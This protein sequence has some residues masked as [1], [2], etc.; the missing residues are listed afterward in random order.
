MVNFTSMRANVDINLLSNHLC[1][2]VAVDVDN[3]VVEV[4]GLYSNFNYTV[5][6]N[7]FDLFTIKIN[8]ELIT[9]ISQT[10]QGESYL[11][12]LVENKFQI[13]NCNLITVNDGIHIF[14][15]SRH[16]T[17]NNQKN[18]INTYNFWDVFTSYKNDT[19]LLSALNYYYER[20]VSTDFFSE[21]IL[22]STASVT[23]SNEQGNVMW[24]ND[25]FQ[26]LTGR[27]KGEIIG[28]RPRQS[29]YGKKS[30]F[31]DTKFV[32][33]NVNERKPFYFENIGYNKKGD[34]YW[35]SAIVY[36]VINMNH[37]I[38]GRIHVMRDITSI[39]IKELNAE[40]NEN[41]LKLALEATNAGVWTLNL[42]TGQISVSEKGN[43]LLGITGTTQHN[44]EA[45]LN[46][47]KAS[48]KRKLIKKIL[49][50]TPDLPDFSEEIEHFSKYVNDIR[51]LFIKGKV[52][53]HDSINQSVV[54]VGTI[55]DI[56]NEKNYTKEIERQ[57]LFYHT[58]LNNLPS[59]VVMWSID[60]RYQFVNKTAV[61]DDY[62]RNWLV[63]KDDFEYCEMKG[64]DKELAFSRR[65]EFNTMLNT[66]QPVRFIEKF[67]KGKNIYKLR[68]L[69]P[70][71]NI[72]NDIEFVIGY[73]IDISEQ[74]ENE[75]YAKLQEAR[76]R[77]FLDITKEGVFRINLQGSLLAYNKTLLSLLMIDNELIDKN[78]LNYF[79]K[80][81]RNKLTSEISALSITKPVSEGEFSFIAKNGEERIYEYS[82][83]LIHNELSEPELL[84]RLNDIT[85]VYHNER[86][87]KANIE[88]EIY[89]NKYKSQFIRITSHELRTPLA[90]IK[91]NSEL[92][93]YHTS[94]KSN[95]DIL[96]LDVYIDRIIKQVD[97]MSEILNQ[98]LM[99]SK[100]EDGNLPLSVAE[101]DLNNF[102]LNE[103]VV[104]YLPYKDGRS[105]YV[106]APKNIGYV[107]A[108]V[109]LFKLALKNIIENAFKYSID[110]EAPTLQLIRDNGG[111]IIKIVDNGIGIPQM[112]IKELFK[113]FYR[114]SNVGAISGT[115]IGL[116]LVDFFVKKHGFSLKIDSKLNV[117]TS[118][119][120]F[121]PEQ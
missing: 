75:Q 65:R 18:I 108:D 74:I 76:I 4:G 99:I 79:T 34:E 46:V 5:P 80:E 39:K 24:C 66:R 121:I 17:S 107:K 101:I 85:K 16:D 89:L 103:V 10:K 45:I 52:I 26:K 113:S 102:I 31:I 88:K 105:L 7:V 37:D 116:V 41:I 70:F 42:K 13:L 43:D 9:S 32:D 56:T 77:Q 58:I 94:N 72:N 14:C 44:I 33:A 22:D 106:N 114:A 28:I 98:L 69:H 1:F 12:Q 82:I 20:N 38:V 84:G 104:N 29:M 48:E 19:I 64:I 93:D 62:T 110:K 47:F 50:L 25:N 63:G 119:E 59:D 15:G 21:I 40:E 23:L 35:F 100:I 3:I 51:I 49:S 91:S 96:R 57:K 11:F 6:C 118:V 90:I 81:V 115:G 117:G 67:N 55:F 73:G 30:V 109:S 120:I 8:D 54:I 71:I 86:I 83:S 53:K 61:S 112:E 97:D 92:L 78:L 2:Y 111:L 68:I 95:N 87:L 36:P 60:H 27:D